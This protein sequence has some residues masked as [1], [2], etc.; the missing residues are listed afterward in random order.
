MENSKPL[1][2]PTVLK[3]GNYL[4]WSRTTKTALC[5][6]GLWSHIEGTRAPKKVTKEDG[7]E[8]T[9]EDKKSLSSK[10]KSNGFK[11]TRLELW[12]TL[13]NVFGNISNLTR[14]FDVKKAI[15]DLT[16][17][18]MQFNKHFGKFRSLWAEFEMLRPNTM[19]LAV[20][21][22][23]REQ[24]KVFAL[25]LTLNR[26]FNDLIKHILRADKLP[27]LDD[28]CSHI[29]KEQGSLGLFM[30][31]GELSMAN[32]GTYRPDER[33]S[34]GGCEHCKR[35]NHTKDK[36][37][38]LHPHLRPNVIN[39][40]PIA[41]ITRVKDEQ[42]DA[43]AS[44]N[45]E[46]MVSGDYV[47]KSDLEAFFKSLAANQDS[48]KTFFTPSSNRSLVVD[49]GASHH[50]ISN[51]NLLDNIKSARGNVIIANG[52]NIPVQGIGSL[53]LFDK[54]SKA[55]YMP[56]F[57]SNLLSV[58][59]ATTD[60]NCYAIFGPNDVQFQDIESGKL[61]G[62][63]GTKDDLYI[64]D[65]P[66]PSASKSIFAS[67]LNVSFN[68]MWHA[69]LG[70]P[71][72]R[73]LE[74]MLPNVLFDHSRCEACILERKNKH[75]MEV[76]R[77]MMFHTNVPKRYWGD[78]VMT[79]CYL[80][81]QISTKVLGDVSPFEVLNTVKPPIDHLKVFGCVCFVF[82]P[83]ELR[84]KLD[85]KST[86]CMFLGYS[87]TQKGYKCFDPA[88]NRI[89]VSRD[90]KFLENQGYFERRDWSDLENLAKPTNRSA[91]L[92]FLLDHLRAQ[93]RTETLLQI[94]G[95]IAPEN[96]EETLTETHQ[97]Q[98]CST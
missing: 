31:K 46:G 50:M 6:R 68:A 94:Q 76:A 84:N 78:A 44:R 4:M 24:D 15:N 26:T 11:K 81:N 20:L 53:R 45:G 21:N 82:I 56:R 41:N 62:E 59:R 93:S 64:L 40:E 96:V 38:F 98:L 25:L 37:W 88:N 18:D 17:E 35:K 72:S 97:L 67:C 8:T 73:A 66:S 86:K 43:G 74:L 2:L 89:F 87:T 83:R 77:S 36:C 51:S 30:G 61:L 12:E 91:S 95:D 69:R 14:V 10:K 92:K 79:T 71:H 32:K 5:G 65:D 60:L 7:R 3:G 27:S 70:H 54:E 1:V 75:L 48:G 19:D 23:R 16:Q 9:K 90:V 63:G 55:F 80:I 39:K 13:K 42:S 85:A 47:K 57:T 52:D 29:Q 34:K 28:V 49:S 58:K 33:R 22:E